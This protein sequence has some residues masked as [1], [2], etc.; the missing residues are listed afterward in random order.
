MRGLSR[1]PARLLSCSK[2]SRV[3]W[4]PGLRANCAFLPSVSEPARIATAKCWYC[5]T[6]WGWP[7]LRSP[8]S[9]AVRQYCQDVRSGGF[10]SDAESY[11]APRVAKEEKEA[12]V[13]MDG[14]W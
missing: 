10:P 13:N 7:L 8:I 1:P 9:G 3:N 14:D 11:H 12:P 4:R 2:L 5:T 6:S